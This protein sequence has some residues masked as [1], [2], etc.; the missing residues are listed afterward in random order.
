MAQWFHDE[1]QT[2]GI[3][4]CGVAI[5]YLNYMQ[6]LIMMSAAKWDFIISKDAV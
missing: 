3:S 6:V 2:V 4:Q 1:K 5:I